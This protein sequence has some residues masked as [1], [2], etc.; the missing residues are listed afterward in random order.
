MTLIF[1][2]LIVGMGLATA[3]LRFYTEDTN[4]VARER[5]VCTSVLMTTSIAVV[6]TIIGC[7]YNSEL[8][9]F[10]LRKSGFGRPFTMMMFVL[11]FASIN[12][13]PLVV[14]RARERPAIFLF[15]SLAQLLIGVALNIFFMVIL[16][17]GVVGWLL[18][19]LWTS[20]IV[21]AYLMFSTLASVDKVRFSFT[22]L[23]R[24]WTYSLPLIPASLAMF[25]IHNGD[26]Y[27][28]SEYHTLDDV[29]V[30]S[31][32]YKFA[33]MIP[34]LIGGPF[35]MSWSVRMF[36]VF[37]EEGG[38]KVYA[39]TLTYYT[40]VLLMFL[41]FLSVTIKGVIEI[42][43]AERVGYYGAYLVVPFI[44]LGYVMREFSDFFKGVLLIKR[45]TSFVGMNTLI[46]AVVCTVL[47]LILI[48]AYDQAGAAWATLLTFSTMALC[49]YVVSQRIHKVPYEFGRIAVMAGLAGALFAGL[50]FVDLADPYLDV[51]LKGALS[52]SFYPILY[53]FGFFTADEKEKIR[54]GITHCLSLLRIKGPRTPSQ[55][56]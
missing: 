39:R 23:K 54:Q 10:I 19:T 16:R 41:L 37:E 28:L 25:W 49:M 22:L 46:A 7:T 12:E 1:I 9:S 14:L 31:L 29:G 48:P 13:I 26:R 52:L 53:L 8:S 44:G 47:Y 33:F 18:S 24:M 32:G 51:L 50:S 27:L 55:R 42:T 20:V 56:I 30:Y 34:V 45:R 36:Y 6:I 17:K 15:V 40:S 35:F 38:E 21:C 3:I 5:V 11:L 2:Q 43:A 4:R